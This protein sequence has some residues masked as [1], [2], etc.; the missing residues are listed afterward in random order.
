M[1]E[2]DFGQQEEEGA[3]ADGPEGRQVEP[4]TQ[5]RKPGRVGR[6]VRRGL[7][8]ITAGGVVFL[9]GVLIV[10]FVRV[11]PQA[12]QIK[13]LER[14]LDET[15]TEVESLQ[16]RIDRLEPLEEEIDQLEDEL[17][18]KDHHL[19]L[20]A[21]LVDVTNA[22]LGLAKGEP[23][24]AAGALEMTDR[25]LRSLQQGLDDPE[26]QTVQGMRDRL[27]LVVQE[28]ETD[29]FAAEN[30]LEILANNLVDL[31]RTLFGE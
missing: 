14:T 1:Q 2:D 23:A 10:F 26:E 9:L 18:V 16:S 27:R 21:V 28:I 15:R 6:I 4:P 13:R 29:E 31:E 12:D 11:R 5:P 3:P 8:W 17:A 22:Q 19:D 20:L 30:D 25:R 24:T 7:Q